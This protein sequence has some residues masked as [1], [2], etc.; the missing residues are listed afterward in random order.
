M[1]PTGQPS[2]EENIAR[3]Q[4]EGGIAK[5]TDKGNFRDRNHAFGYMAVSMQGLP[6]EAQPTLS[7]DCTRNGCRVGRHYLKLWDF[8]K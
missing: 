6:I 4:F 7:H 5:D 1:N 2:R 8:G 3:A